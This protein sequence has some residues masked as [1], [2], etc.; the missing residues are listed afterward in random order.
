MTSLAL[1]HRRQFLHLAAGAA[2]LPFGPHIALAQPYPSR[3]VR[4]VVGYTPGGAA[5]IVARVIAQWLSERLGQPVI[6]EN[7]PG[8]GS[9][10]SVQSVLSAPADGYTLLFAASAQAI[11]A[12][13]YETLPFNFVRDFSPVAS[14]TEVP[15]V[16]V[17]NPSIP[18]KTVSDFIS[19]AKTRPGKIS[20]ASFG[21][22]TSSHL[23]GELFKAMARVDMTHV[24]YRGSA[25][26]LSDLIAGRVDLMFDTL[27]A[28]LPHIRSGALR[29]LAVTGNARSE[30][31]PDIPPVGETLSGYEAVGW[32]GI[33][34]RK[35]TPL[36]IV[37]RINREINAGLASTAIRMRFAELAVTARPASP[38]EFGEF[39]AAETDKWAK[40]VKLSGAT[41]E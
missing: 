23:A 29:A 6:V 24:P 33:A 40:V 4:I 19:Y 22:G 31:V 15:L 9:N 11:N 39:V 21:T 16:M 37:Q 14:L 36:E 41:A 5:D 28:C 1:P 18:S 12:S 35:G 26:A 34:V 30:L 27:L 32:Q 10:L 2:V 8:A 7:R 3:L 38:A 25:P 13:L 20:M 17:V